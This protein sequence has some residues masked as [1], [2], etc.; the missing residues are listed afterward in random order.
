MPRQTGSAA[1]RE[2]AIEAEARTA[3]VEAV[4]R[5]AARRMH[6]AQLGRGWGAWVE[7]CDARAHAFTQIRRA[8]SMLRSPQLQRAYSHWAARSAAARH[9]KEM[10]EQKRSAASLDTLR[11][12]VLASP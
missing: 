4:R 2:A 9:K 6:H 7:H 8:A 3:R 1:E 11:L 10:A 12:E 5:Q